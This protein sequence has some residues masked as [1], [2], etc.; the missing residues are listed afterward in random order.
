MAAKITYYDFCNLHYAG[1]YV[2]GFQDNAGERGYQFEVSNKQPPE[3][4]EIDLHKQWLP[5]YLSMFLIFRY[6]GEESFLFAVDASDLNGDVSMGGYVIPL[7][8]I[9]RY[10]FKV[11]YNKEAIA[12]NPQLAPFQH[13]ILPLPNVFPVAVSQPWRFL[14]K[15]TPFGSPI[16]PRKAIEW[17]FKALR[18]IPSLDD[19]R[20]MRAL[21]KDIDVFYIAILRPEDGKPVNVEPNR[22]RRA[23][24]EGL[25]K[26]GRYNIMA[27]YLDLDGSIGGP[28]VVPRMKVDKYLN[29]MARSRINIYVR[30]SSGCR[31]FK[32]GEL[33]ALGNAIVGETI[34]NNREMM[35]GFDYFE[36]QFAYDE[37]EEM[38]ERIIDMLEH[39]TLI[40]DYSRANQETFEKRLA[41]GPVVAAIL[42]KLES[43]TGPIP[44]IASQPV[45][46]DTP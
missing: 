32:F 24:V 13:K 9:C 19:Y 7:L 34:L 45:A 17:R 2:K 28:L 35:Y 22:R 6:E 29:Y 43:K 36:E 38:I 21:P 33:M 1:F 31:S 16:W 5:K 40:E 23:I 37:P 25:N 8:N 27:R 15:L 42:D 30:G 44:T 3:L 14:P 26:Y 39:P 18:T 41:P 46:A 4:T 11:N 20:R 10:Y 12:G